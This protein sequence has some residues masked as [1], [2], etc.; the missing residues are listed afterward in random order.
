MSNSV[1]GVVQTF[2]AALAQ[3]HTVMAWPRH[4][5]ST[6]TLTVE[7]SGDE[8]KYHLEYCNGWDGNVKVKAAS[9]ESLLREV[10]HR[11][12][13]NDREGPKMDLLQITRVDA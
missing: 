3:I 10:S 6:L 1:M 12:D 7:Y 9:L 4:K 13:F 5:R 2:R 11:L 8:A